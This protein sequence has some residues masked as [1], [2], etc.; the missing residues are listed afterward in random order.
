MSATSLPEQL[1]SAAR[2]FA[3]RPHGLLIGG[4]HAPAADGATFETVDPATGDPTPAVAQA[5]AD[6]VDRA[7]RAARTA[8][9]SGWATLP[10]AGRARV[11]NRLADLV[12]AN[13]GE[14][15]ELGALDNGKPLKLAKAIDVADAVRWLR[16]FAGWPERLFGE[17]IPVA[18]ENMHVYT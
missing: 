9:D 6:D 16:H 17:V 7:V 1:S 4:E 10:A 13:A 15:A 14:L 8:F 12:E 3:G 11:L 5:G 2:D 18:Q